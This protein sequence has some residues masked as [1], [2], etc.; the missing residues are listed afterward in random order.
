MAYDREN[1]IVYVDPS[2]DPDKGVE[3]ADIQKV[4][5]VTIKRTVNGVTEARSSSDLG[6]LCS[7][8][9]GDSVPDNAGGRAWTVSSRIDINIWAK[10]KPVRFNQL[11]TTK[12]P[13]TGVSWLNADKT[14][15]SNAQ[16]NRYRRVDYSESS[17]R[18]GFLIP[19][20]RGIS[21]NIE[22][23]LQSWQYLRPRGEGSDYF[24]P[25]R[26]L[27]FNQYY[28]KAICP[29]SIEYPERG[30]LS[31]ELVNGYYKY[32]VNGLIMVSRYTPIDTSER[33]LN[34]T[35]NE[36][37]GLS[38][39]TPVYIGIAAVK[40]NNVYVKTQASVSD[41]SISLEGLEDCGI[42]ENDTIRLVAF[43]SRFSQPTW[44]GE[45][46]HD[47]FS[48]K[49]PN[50]SFPIAASIQIKKEKLD[51]YLIKVT[52]PS[53]APTGD[54]NFMRVDP[55][56]AS[57]SGGYVSTHTQPT[58]TS[59]ADLS[60]A[61][62]L[63][64]IVVSV[65]RMPTGTV[66]WTSSNYTPSSL[67]AIEPYIEPGAA[68]YVGYTLRCLTV[69]NDAVLPTISTTDEWFEWTYNFVYVRA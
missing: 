19:L 55:H 37:L 3:I 64:Y 31:R 32:V 61:Y 63:S 21:Q 50:L 44:S 69:E 30:V 25:F 47:V 5:P 14:W 60:W 58:Q 20:E 18:Y 12:H 13:T 10:Y 34:L 8:Q 17:Y 65:K 42:V 1:K 24:E 57:K 46:N 43:G 68:T 35:L 33:T 11:D 16:W 62:N 23:E 48:L 4:V 67:N 51:K 56:G 54:V 7:A 45:F 53:N 28:H 15:N 6:V 36:I 29:F 52:L 66:V 9:V 38:S 59:Q 2:T 39:E 26:K 40:G 27:D 49:A 41:A 22:S